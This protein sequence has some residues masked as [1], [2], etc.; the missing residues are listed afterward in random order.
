MKGLLKFIAF[1]IFY[2][3]LLLFFFDK[4]LRYF[5]KRRRL[6]LTY[7]GISAN[8]Q[9]HIN[10][11]H[12]EAVQFEKH[13]KYFKK[14]FDV[15][16]LETI[17]GMTRL[18]TWP[19]RH[20]IA[21]TL[22]DGFL[23]NLQVAL[24]LLEK[25]ELPATFFCCSINLED[26]DYIHPS[27]HFDLIRASNIDKVKIREK[28]FVN[29]KHHLINLDDG[30][31]AS[32]FINSLS[33]ADWKSALIDL[34]RAYPPK[35]L[36]ISADNEVYKLLNAEQLKQISSSSLA[37]IGSHCHAHVNVKMLSE[38]EMK[39]QFQCSK[40]LLEKCSGKHVNSIAYPYGYYN[41]K[42]L[43]VA[44]EAGYEYSIGAGDVEEKLKDYVFPRQVVMGAAGY[45][46]NILAIVK[47][48]NRFGF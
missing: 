6:I 14:N 45:A 36:P 47:G 34:S 11:R 18:N 22:D 30:T 12:I 10:G 28:E 20:T 39:H 8:K 42:A 1:D 21:I 4:V 23:N 13:L 5:A 37:S 29:G 27:D 3:L 26:E 19:R 35:T 15:V 38:E 16:S 7:H 48:F 2:S 43:E 9:F 41:E 40:I 31:T 24:P 44:Q 33:Y 46:R 17:C 32:E 25:Y